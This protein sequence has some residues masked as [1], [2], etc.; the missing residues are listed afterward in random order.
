[1]QLDRRQNNMLITKNTEYHVRNRECVG[2]RDRISGTW[3]TKHP[4]LRGWLLG[5]M[6]R[7]HKVFPV[8]PIGSRLVIS[9]GSRDVLTSPLLEIERPEKLAVERYTWRAKAGTIEPRFI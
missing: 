3:L 6:D 2:V 5:G 4:A 1:M 7:Q 8:P 9:S